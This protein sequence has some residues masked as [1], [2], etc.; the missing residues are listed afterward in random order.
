MVTII[1][2]ERSSFDVLMKQL[3]SGV[4]GALP[5]LYE[6]QR[7]ERG[8]NA[9]NNAEQEIAGAGNDPYKIA[10]ALAKAGVQA[11]G[12]E[13][14]MGPL[15]Q[16][17][18][19]N[20]V[21]KNA[22]PGAIGGQSQGNM[23][24]VPSPMVNPQ[25]IQAPLAESPSMQGENIQQPEFATPSPFNIMTAPEI[26]A[27]SERY[28]LAT[29]DPNNFAVRQTQLENQNTIASKQRNDLE[30]LALK[31]GIKPEELPRFMQI[32]SKFDPRNP[33]EWMLKAGREYNKI[34][35]N[36]EKIDTTFIPGIGQ[37]LLGF[38]R[39]K[40]LKRLTPVVQ[41]QVAK[42]LEQET[43]NKL[44]DNYLTPTEIELQIHPLTPKQ[45]KSIEK[46]PRGFFPAQTDILPR[47]ETGFEKSP[48]KSYEEAL[49]R[50]PREMKQIQDKL[51][52]FFTENVDDKT[53]LL[54]LREKLW[55][56]RD[57]DWRQ[58]GPAIRQAEEKGLK[59]TPAQ[60]TEMAEI[61][62][63]PPYQSLPDIFRDWSRIPAYLRGSK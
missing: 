52:D 16:T 1:P 35:S 21:T 37:G 6:N 61:E 59:L 30:G 24:T 31:S 27:E 50:A 46:F 36:D 15:L 20:A 34:K 45:E 55:K 26:Q 29:R 42:G 32:A 13:R 19:T 11:P 49:E 44:A 47:K 8:V 18:M 60:S 62:T 10:L 23:P 39:E 12:L 28:A 58:I 57:Y 40:E 56:D 33:T 38:D 53:S 43:R 25:Q 48:F 3:G 17:A 2:P 63:Q 9:L 5:Q 22:F 41:D 7:R 14:A 4:Q 54:G 51:A